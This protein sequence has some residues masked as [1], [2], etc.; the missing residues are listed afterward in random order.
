VVPAAPSALDDDGPS[1]R[2]VVARVHRYSAL[3]AAERALFPSVRVRRGRVAAAPGSA[4]FQELRDLLSELRAG[5]GPGE[6]DLLPRLA[7]LDERLEELA[8]EL[9]RSLE[10][11]PLA[12][13]RATL[14]ALP[15]DPR[16]EAAAL[17]DLC[18]RADPLVPERLPAIDYLVTFVASEGPPGLRRV[19]SDPACATRALAL[20]ARRAAEAGPAP[21]EALAA[22]RT[23]SEAMPRERDVAALLRRMRGLKHE[24]GESLLVPDVLR[25]AVDYNCAASNRVDGMAAQQRRR[26]EEAHAALLAEVGEPPAPGSGADAG[27]ERPASALASRGL[28]TLQAALALRL[29]GERATGP[30]A[31]LAA[32]VDVADLA[33][34]EVRALTEPS[35]GEAA[36]LLRA[37]VTVGLALRELPTLREQLLRIEIEPDTLAGR[38]AS[39]LDEALA[40]AVGELARRGHGDAARRLEH[41]RER[42]SPRQA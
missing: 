33:G 23:A 12:Q 17:L 14:P 16:Q 38:F 11:L 2:A 36:A 6:Q 1:E 21:A 22:L 37:A 27:L 20:R 3:R 8:A 4:L 5:R 35:G 30:A 40:G 10:A 9:H 24:L 32:A 42:L 19:G 25:A 15:G 34:E 28:A 7:T 26:D 39:E 13:L 18:L 29:R 41:T 31:E